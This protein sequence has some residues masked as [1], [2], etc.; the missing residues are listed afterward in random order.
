[1]PESCQEKLKFR[2]AESAFFSGYG[3][4]PEKLNVNFNTGMCNSYRDLR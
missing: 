4:T 2:F 1:M 3:I